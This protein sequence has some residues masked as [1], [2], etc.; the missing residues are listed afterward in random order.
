ML[1]S[2]LEHDFHKLDA[3]KSRYLGGDESHTHLVK[4]LDFVL[5][6]QVCTK[7]VLTVNFF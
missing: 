4:G 2:D 6:A 5:L 3:E 1:Y 7:A